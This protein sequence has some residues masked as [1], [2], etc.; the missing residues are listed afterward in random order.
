MGSNSTG[1]KGKGEAVKDR[2]KKRK[3]KAYQFNH[4]YKIIDFLD[5]DEDLIGKRKEFREKMRAFK[6]ATYN[7]DH[8]CKVVE[9]ELE[10]Y[11]VI[12]T[13]GVGSYAVVKLVK[14]KETGQEFAIKFYSRIEMLDFVKMK[15]YQVGEK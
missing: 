2:K 14:H 4:M 12:K 8:N 10:D 9:K 3:M 11:E 15:N 13:I 5:K 7:D 1:S 6:E